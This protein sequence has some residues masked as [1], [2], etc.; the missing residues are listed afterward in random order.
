MNFNLFGGGKIRRTLS[1]PGWWN[2]LANK[3]RRTYLCYFRPDYVQEQEASRVGECVGCGK[4]CTLVFRCVF[5]EGSEEQSRC[6]IYDVGRPKPCGAFP[7]DPK[8]LS[9]VNFLCG[10]SFITPG[11]AKPAFGVLPPIEVTVPETAV[12]YTVNRKIEA[13]LINE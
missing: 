11:A 13:K 1:N 6:K 10:Y 12:V 4:C 9:D 5:L 3:V 7:I 8:D 2:M